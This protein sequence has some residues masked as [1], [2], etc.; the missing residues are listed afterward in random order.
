MFQEVLVGSVYLPVCVFEGEKR[1]LGGNAWF[2]LAGSCLLGHSS[3]NHNMTNF[4]A[5]LSFFP[6]LCLCGSCSPNDSGPPQMAKAG[7]GRSYMPDVATSVWER[8]V[9]EI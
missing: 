7:H 6:T 8:F 3:G 5:S 2:F 4:P 1:G 9:C